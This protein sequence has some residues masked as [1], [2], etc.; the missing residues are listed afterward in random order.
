MA[1]SDQQG[2]DSRK[3]GTSGPGRSSTPGRP[4][5]SAPGRSG[6]RPVSPARRPVDD[7]PLRVLRAV[8]DVRVALPG[9]PRALRRETRQ[10]SLRQP[11]RD[12][13]VE[14]GPPMTG[15]LEQ[16]LRRTIAATKGARFYLNPAARG[17]VVLAFW[18]STE[19]VR[20]RVLPRQ[21]RPRP[22]RARPVRGRRLPR[23]RG[24]AATTGA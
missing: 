3:E 18:R 1:M 17:A 24:C 7:G 15:R 12:P 6:A 4:S 2:G 23:L 11:R 22:E 14:H 10:N 9:V 13:L 19:L 16:N 5:R 8:R 20:R 21:H